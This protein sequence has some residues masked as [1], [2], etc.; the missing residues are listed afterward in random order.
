[1]IKDAPQRSNRLVLGIVF[2]CTAAT[3]FPMM[4]GIVQVL[5]PRYS[6]EQL[7]WVRIVGHL[8]FVLAVFGPQVGF[9]ALFRTVQPGAQFARSMCQLTS[10]FCFFNGVKFLPLAKAA[11]ISFMAPLIVA[12]LA[13]PMLGERVA[14]NR[15]VAVAIGFL[16]VLVVIRPGADVFHWASLLLLASAASYALYQIITRR[17]AGQDSPETSAL[18]SCLLGVAVMSVIVPFRWSP[19][20][21]W[22]DATL[23]AALGVFGGLGHYCVARAMTYGQASLIAPFGYWQM[24]GSVI[25]GYLISD[26]WPDTGVWLGASIIIGAGLYIGWSETRDRRRTRAAAM[27]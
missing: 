10:T 16:G 4:N 22:M 25:I 2:M 17:V 9:A 24:V 6:S 3:L 14:L 1:M 8:I 27:A 5:S 20:G 13:W 19:I 18:Y 21:S 12:V 23:M 15:L 11:S 26:K 7:V